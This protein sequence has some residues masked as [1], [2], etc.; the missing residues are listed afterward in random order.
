[1][2]NLE[3]KIIPSSTVLIIR[4][5]TYGLEVFMVVRHH[6][7]DFAAG[8]LV[9]PGGKV[10]KSDYDKKLNQ[11]L[12]EEETS[13]RENSPFKIAAVRECFEEANVLFVKNKV[14][15]AVGVTEDLITKIQADVL[16]QNMSEI[17]GGKG[18]GRA[19][20]A[21]AG[22]PNVDNLHKSFDIARDCIKNL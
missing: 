9:F 2:N 7:I 11:Y 16:A 14:R 12:C 6:E 17:L 3:N 8:A 10:D 4:D 13:D 18:G 1:M 21:N 20:F 22:G 15:I 5:G 19:N